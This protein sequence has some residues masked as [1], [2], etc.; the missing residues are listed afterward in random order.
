MN[1]FIGE[2]GTGKTHLMKL[3]YCAC[4]ASRQD[5]SFP[6]KIAN[7]FKP[8]DFRIARLISRKSHGSSSEFKVESD[9]SYIKTSFTTRT[10]KWNADINGED[11]WE[12]NN[13][14][15]SCR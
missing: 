1:I 6:H 12:K 8:D 3:L 15:Y 14:Y 2:N 11:K 13:R 5:V 7:V 4:Q 10:K 9:T